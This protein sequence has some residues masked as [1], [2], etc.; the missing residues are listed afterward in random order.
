MYNNAKGLDKVEITCPPLY[1]VLLAIWQ[2][3]T[4][5]KNK[6]LYFGGVETRSVY[7]R[8]FSV[9]SADIPCTYYVHRHIWP[10]LWSVWSIYGTCTYQ[11]MFWSIWYVHVPNKPN[12]YSVLYIAINRTLSISF[13]YSTIVV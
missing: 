5:R 4:T 11:G 3:E 13:Q 12:S 1:C 7:E 10:Q 6:M 8:Y 9:I 2:S